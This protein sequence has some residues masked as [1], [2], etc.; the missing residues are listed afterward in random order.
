MKMLGRHGLANLGMLFISKVGGVLVVLLFMPLFY[1]LLGAEQFGV[2]AVVLSLQALLV[3]LD[4]GM[5]TMV[6]RDVAVLGGSSIQA[7]TIWRNA[8]AVLTLFYSGLL[9][10]AM[11]WGMISSPGGLSVVLMAAIAMLFWVMVL[12]NLGQTVLLG[13]KS[14]KA[15]SS[16]Q[17]SGAL[18]RAGVT[19]LALQHFG[20]TLQVFIVAQLITSILQLLVTRWACIKAL[21]EHLPERNRRLQRTIKTR[22]AIIGF[23]FGW[24]GGD[25]AR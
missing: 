16:I 11:A 4:L 22:Q 7:A 9:L 14:F 3:M 23:W 21:T 25:A 15:A 10:L 20:S 2:V 19:A 13:A 24:C 17:L 8:E 6:G 5:S 12:Q 1:R 18:L